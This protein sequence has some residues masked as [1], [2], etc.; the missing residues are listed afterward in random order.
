MFYKKKRKI[1][2]PKQN[3]FTNENITKNQIDINPTIT[4]DNLYQSAINRDPNFHTKFQEYYP[5]FAKKLLSLNNSLQN[6]ELELLAYI[7]LKIETKKIADILYLSPKT[8]QNRKYNVRKKLNI[9]SSTSVY[10]WLISLDLEK[11]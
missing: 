10:I 1:S 11:I 5:D 2:I 4:L 6:S 7:Y 8:I 3:D 9:P